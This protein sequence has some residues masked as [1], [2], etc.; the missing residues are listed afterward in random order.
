MDKIVDRFLYES[1][2]TDEV[3]AKVEREVTE[4]L[5]PFLG[6]CMTQHTLSALEAAVKNRLDD[7][8]RTEQLPDCIGYFTFFQDNTYQPS[9]LITVYNKP[10]FRKTPK[11]SV[12]YTCYDIEESTLYK[13]VVKE[14]RQK[15]DSI[16]YTVEYM[17]AKDKA[18]KAYGTCLN[19]L[20][21]DLESKYHS[22]SAAKDAKKDRIMC[23]VEKCMEAIAE[24]DSIEED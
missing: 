16:V 11:Y 6:T 9:K 21:W 7:L 4:C 24:I 19:M 13:Y 15:G 22:I 20:E 14:G 23:A 1:L 3:L 2:V 17:E 8:V 10:F 18:S 5:K 12:G